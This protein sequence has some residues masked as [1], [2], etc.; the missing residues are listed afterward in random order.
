MEMP[1]RF[2][3]FVQQLAAIP[4]T[5][6]CHNPY[7]N[8][9]ARQHN[10][11]CYLQALQEQETAVLLIGEAPGYRGCRLSGIPFVSRDL[12]LRP[13]SPLPGAPFQPVNE[14]PDIEK[15]AS[16]TIMWETI[17]QLPTL[18]LLWNIFP[19]HPHKPNQP[20][21]NRAPTL[22]EIEQGR[23]FLHQL[24]THFPIQEIVAVG[25]KAEAALT[26][27]QLAHRPVRHPSHGGKRPFQHALLT[28][29]KNA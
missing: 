9:P 10:L 26:R 13:D 14:W 11:L 5:K 21:S 28:G 17:T 18:P 7:K 3:P 20:R 24:L 6:T 29:G 23:P 25:R 2:N 12:L 22:A 16:A 8:S 27:W 4:H 19:L 1:T 15:E